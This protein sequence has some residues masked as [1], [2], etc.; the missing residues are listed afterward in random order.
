MNRPLMSYLMPLMLACVAASPR[1]AAE[2]ASNA[3]KT[4]GKREAEGED[5]APK[6]KR[7]RG[8]PKGSGG[9]KK[10]GRAGGKKGESSKVLRCTSINH[11]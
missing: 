5:G 7:G 10:K 11:D 8:R 1:K 4:S 3:I 6:A 2:A 9:G